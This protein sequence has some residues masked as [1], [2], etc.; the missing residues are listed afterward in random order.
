MK[1]RR[2]APIVTLSLALLAGCGE[3]AQDAPEA[4][5]DAAPETPLDA[6]PAPP[7]DA[8]P[9][10]EPEPEP[11]DAALDAPPPEA[12]PDAEPWPDP[13]PPAAPALAI[14]HAGRVLA[15]GETL[16]LAGPPAGLDAAVTIE[17]TLVWR[18]ADAIT[19]DP[20][21]A[22]WLDAPGFTWIT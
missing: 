19:W 16:R 13:L 2:L 10:P 12:P 1:A 4:A 11:A 8:A 18:G 20:T 3:P 9:A 7:A 14:V 15:P 17:L 6:A 5:P 22:A 21:P